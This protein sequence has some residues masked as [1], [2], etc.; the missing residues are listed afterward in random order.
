MVWPGG[1]PQEL[2][3]QLVSLS[4]GRYWLEMSL[5]VNINY[6]EL[7]PSYNQ[8]A[9]QLQ[10]TTTSPPNLMD[11]SF[12]SLEICENQEVDIISISS[13]K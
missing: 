2:L 11:Q 4:A 8:R 13:G 1:S 5:I 9:S 12:S 3:V 10:E 7:D 6:T